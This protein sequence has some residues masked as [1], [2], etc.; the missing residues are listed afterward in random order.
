MD[1]NKIMEMAKGLDLE[2]IGQL[3]N[4]LQQLSAG[5]P[6]TKTGSDESRSEIE[7]LTRTDSVEL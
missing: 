1:I 4:M 2:K 6:Q 3:M 5:I 7:M